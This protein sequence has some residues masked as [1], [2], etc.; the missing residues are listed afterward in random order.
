MIEKSTTQQVLAVFFENPTQQFHLRELSRKTKLSLPTI[1]STTKKLC[2]EGLITKKKS[3]VLTLVNANNENKQFIQQKR[4]FNLEQLYQ[5]GLT[6]FLTKKYQQPKTIIIF[7]SYSRGED[8][9]KSD[10]DIAIITHKRLETNLE[11]YEHK[12]HR[13]I[14][15]HEIDL[16][17]ISQEFKNS[18]YN[19]IVVE[20]Q[21]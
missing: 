8:T 20:G 18:L 10:I 16:N 3:A 15:I 6:Y 12:L 11:E 7:G 9:E 2:D 19:G 4:F 13:T 1:L 5:S 14:N 21:L 17:K